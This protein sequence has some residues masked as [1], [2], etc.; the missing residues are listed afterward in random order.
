MAGWVWLI[1]AVAYLTSEALSATRVAGYSYTED[2]ISDLGVVAVMN[3]GFMVHGLL[4]LFGALVVTRATSG[5]GWA[6]RGFVLSATANAVGNVL[7]GAFHSGER[8][9]VVGAGLAIV[10]G[11]AA[12]I[13]A[14]LGSRR[15]GAT[16]VYRAGSVV[17]GVVGL[18]CLAV[19][20]IDGVNG[21]RVLPVGVVERGSV[22][23][24]IAW[25]LVTALVL[26]R[27]RCSR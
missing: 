22:Y 18:A 17:V 9:H 4:F 19:L 2:Y 14:G 11:N 27:G 5:L 25:E 10:G 20:V 3:Y 12:L 15:L 7:V 23:S 26:T 16:G 6:G 21:P 8:W 13:V 1:G 24:I